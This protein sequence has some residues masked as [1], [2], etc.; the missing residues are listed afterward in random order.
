MVTVAVPD[1]APFTVAS[2]PSLLKPMV[3]VEMGLLPVMFEAL[4]A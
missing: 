4:P 3:P 2:E 1:A